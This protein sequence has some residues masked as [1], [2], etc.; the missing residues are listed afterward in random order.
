MVII[1]K[2]ALSI[3]IVAILLFTQLA[4]PTFA[5]VDAEKYNSIT[6]SGE[7]ELFVQFV[8]ID[9]KDAYSVKMVDILALG[10][11]ESSL[12]FIVLGDDGEEYTGVYNYK[13]D[14][15]EMLLDQDV[16][17]E[18][19]GL[20]SNTLK[21]NRWFMARI[22]M[23][24][25]L[26]RSFMYAV[27]SEDVY[28]VKFNGYDSQAE[29][30]DIDA[31]VAIAIMM[32]A[33]GT[34]AKDANYIYHKLDAETVSEY[35]YVIFGVA[36]ADVTVSSFYNEEKELVC[37]NE[38]RNIDNMYV[39]ETMT[40][41]DGYWTMGADIY[42]LSVSDEE[43]GRVEVTMNLEYY[44]DN[45]SYEKLNVAGDANGDGKV[46]AIDAR[47]MLQYVAGLID[48]S[49]LNVQLCDMN[50]DGRVTAADVRTVLQM[51]AGLA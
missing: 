23:E 33:D 13:Y 26:L 15:E 11:N 32:C 39:P 42:D 43:I 51:A 37:F 46:S 7:N 19:D 27:D 48:E 10:V 44:I 20:E 34:A 29:T 30:L 31:M 22:M 16:S 14:T 24:S 28:G 9:D 18:I 36:D 50:G 41:A 35:I 12:D 40:Y 38:S 3:L 47:I 5:Q 8:G 2:K 21:T 45:I 25:A 6:I 1:M 49:E 4:L 17:I